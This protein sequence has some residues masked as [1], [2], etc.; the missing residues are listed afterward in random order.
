MV[1]ENNGLEWGRGRGKG[2]AEVRGM[3][4]EERGGE[5]GSTQEKVLKMGTQEGRGERRWGKEGYI[6]GGKRGSQEG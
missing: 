6:R 2:G 3:G 1:E 5:G 4:E